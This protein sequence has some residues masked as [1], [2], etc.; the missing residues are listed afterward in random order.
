M[1]KVDSEVNAVIT[2]LKRTCAIKI[3]NKTK[4]IDSNSLSTK[5]EHLILCVD[6]VKSSLFQIQI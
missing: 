1:L 5:K 3:L 6:L 4:K 2:I